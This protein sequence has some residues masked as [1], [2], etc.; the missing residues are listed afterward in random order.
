MTSIARSEPGRTQRVP[1][2]SSSRA[3][4]LPAATGVAWAP[5][6]ASC[7]GARESAP[8]Q[9]SAVA[10]GVVAA[11]TPLPKVTRGPSWQMLGVGPCPRHGEQAA[12]VCPPD[13]APGVCRAWVHGGPR[14]KRARARSQHQADP[15]LLCRWRWSPRRRRYHASHRAALGPLVALELP[16]P[17]T[18]RHKGRSRRS[19]DGVDGRIRAYPVLL[20]YFVSA[21]TTRSGA[22]VPNAKQTPN[23]GTFLSC[24]RLP[25]TSCPGS[26][27]GACTRRVFL[28]RRPQRKSHR[29]C[30]LALHSFSFVLQHP[31]QHH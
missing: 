20:R 2:R 3:G 29:H 19:V 30:P 4:L 1:A 28:V 27:S 10:G 13:S 9:A 8:A 12:P 31:V 11:R 16:R 24:S 15:G 6:R 23:D 18:G 5:P 25:C 17:A 21:S 22:A 14:S 26:A 7:A